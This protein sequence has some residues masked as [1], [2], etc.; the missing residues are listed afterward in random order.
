GLDLEEYTR[1]HRE[2]NEALQLDQNWY[3][4]YRWYAIQLLEDWDSSSLIPT[5]K[6]TYGVLWRIQR[7]LAEQ[8]LLPHWW[9][10]VSSYD[11]IAYALGRR[12]DFTLLDGLDVPSEYRNPARVYMALGHLHAQASSGTELAGLPSRISGLNHAMLVNETLQQEVATALGQIF[13][14]S[15]A[16]QEESLDHFYDDASFRRIYGHRTY[17]Q[18]TEVVYYE[19]DE[20]EMEN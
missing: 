11:A 12:G 14:L 19:N 2:E 18:L 16:E 17:D 5:L 20:E 13:G 3:A 6:Q 15:S 10:E 4:V 9:L 7:Y 1:V 8:G